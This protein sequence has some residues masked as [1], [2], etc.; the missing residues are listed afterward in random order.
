VSLEDMLAGWTGPSSDTEQEKQDRTERM[1][2]EA[3]QGHA[4]LRDCSLSAYAKGSYAND[5][6]VRADSDVD[7]AVQCH[8]VFYWEEESPGVHGSITPYEGIW[9]PAKLRTEIGLALRAKFGNQVDESGATAFRV[10]SGTARVDADVVPCFDYRYYFTSGGFREGTRI[11]TKSGVGFENFPVQQL[12]KGNTKNSRTKTYYKKAVRILKR[13]E[14]AMLD[15][16]RHP[17]V[18][19][20]FIEC[21]GYNCPDGMIIESTWT[22]TVR[23]MLIHIWNGLEGGEPSDASSRWLEVSECKYLFLS[24]QKWTRNDGR[25]FAKAAWNYLGYA[26]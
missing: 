15:K 22:E 3:I 12:T 4:G 24:R 20:F 23:R 11:F 13:V 7:V 8:D 1:V 6:N 10:H 17:A 21:L 5:T 19:S 16:G 25:A 18:P 2:R 9:T 14:N 26:S